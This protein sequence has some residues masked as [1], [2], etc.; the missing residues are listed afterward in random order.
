MSKIAL[1]GGGGYIGRHLFKAFDK[2]FR[3]TSFDRQNGFDMCDE[4]SCKKHITSG[5]FDI[6]I[7]L[8]SSISTKQENQ[9][10]LQNQLFKNNLFCLNRLLCHLCTL[11]KKPKLIYFSSMSVYGMGQKQ[12]LSEGAKLAP[13]HEY[14][15]SKLYAESLVRFYAEKNKFKSVIFRPAGVFGGDRK[16]GYIYSTIKKLINSETVT[17][18]TEGLGYWE[19]INID[20]LTLMV[21]DFLKKYDFKKNCEVFNLGYGKET[22]FVETAFLL[23][24]MLGSKSE[25]LVENKDY[26]KLFMSRKKISKVIDTKA[27]GYKKALKKYIDEVGHGI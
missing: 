2:E 20:D 19:A 26:E 4:E 1:I 9:I 7:V 23:K 10:D 16:S 17:I 25:I 13:L 21:F 3:C 8:A 11:Q 6:V 24:K 14:G 27:L 22:D 15:L 5:R 18:N 12:P